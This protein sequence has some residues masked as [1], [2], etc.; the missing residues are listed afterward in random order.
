M[1]NLGDV[2]DVRPL[3]I[4]EGV[5][6]RPIEGERMTLAFVE[7]APNAVVPEHRHPNEQLGLML[8]GSGTFRVGDETRQVRAG[9]TWRILSNVPHELAVGPDGAVV[10]DVFSPVRSDWSR[11]EPAE[12]R[13]PDWRA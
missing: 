4:W 13:D 1:D 5:T 2:R 7:L 3:D 8:Q 11:F 6:A 12:P 10:I 9:S